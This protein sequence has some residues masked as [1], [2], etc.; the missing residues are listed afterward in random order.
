MAALLP[1][2][3][4]PAIVEADQQTRV[5]VA[6]VM[7]LDHAPPGYIRICRDPFLGYRPAV[8]QKAHQPDP[9]LPGDER[10]ACQHQEFRELPLGQCVIGGDVGR[11]VLPPARLVGK[12]LVVG[13]GAVLLAW[14][15]G[16]GGSFVVITDY[17]SLKMLSAIERP[18]G[19][20]CIAD[21]TSNRSK[22]L[23]F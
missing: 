8:V 14:G 11:E 10:P 13:I 4:E 6:G 21:V 16:H 12:R 17:P 18:V 2:G 9:A 23:A 22:V 15:K 5:I 19:G 7:E 3:D 20:W 1:E